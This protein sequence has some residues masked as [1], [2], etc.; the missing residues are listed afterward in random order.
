MQLK[1]FKGIPYGNTWKSIKN[2]LRDTHLKL[3][4]G[5]PNEI[6]NNGIPVYCATQERTGI[7]SNL[8]LSHLQ[9]LFHG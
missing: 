4:N 1:H 7:K 9:R 6:S 5:P 8:L 3:S 2:C